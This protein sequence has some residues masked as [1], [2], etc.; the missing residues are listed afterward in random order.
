[1][2]T[3]CTS[4]KQSKQLFSLGLKVITADFYWRNDVLHLMDDDFNISSDVAAWSLSNLFSLLP[5]ELDVDGTTYF[6]HIDK[7]DYMENGEVYTISY[8]YCSRM[9]GS[10]EHFFGVNDA[11][12]IVDAFVEIM[13]FLLRNP[14]YQT[15]NDFHKKYVVDNVVDVVSTGYYQKTISHDGAAFLYVKEITDTKIVC[16]GCYYKHFPT[17]Y[18]IDNFFDKEFSF[19]EFHD[20]GL[21]ATFYNVDLKPI[22]EDSYN[23]KMQQMQDTLEYVRSCNQHS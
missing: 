3:I 21:D 11:P 5:T 22:S 18:L 4:L 13:Y 7:K 14:G 10:W 8:G 9:D 6:L 15:N 1:M 17:H 23:T 19:Q 2:N 12:N 20:F 16:D